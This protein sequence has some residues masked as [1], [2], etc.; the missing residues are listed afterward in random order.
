MAHMAERQSQL[1]QDLRRALARTV[2]AR[3]PYVGRVS[4]HVDRRRSDGHS[5]AHRRA[6]AA[7]SVLHR[8]PRGR[9]TGGNAPRVPGFRVASDLQRLGRVHRGRCIVDVPRACSARRIQPAGQADPRRD[10]VRRQW[11]CRS[12]Q[13][14]STACDRRIP[15]A[16]ESG[17]RAF[18][19][20]LLSDCRSARRGPRSGS[21]LCGR[22]RGGP[23]RNASVAA[24]QGRLGCGALP[25]AK[26]LSDNSSYSERP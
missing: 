5:G 13:R 2:R 9:H 26:L 4:R 24:L 17:R 20:R 12:A 16:A 8:H 22:G 25:A 11:A 3:L 7:D 1:S 19:A 18:R 15:H 14:C 6:P 21:R 10:A 23:V